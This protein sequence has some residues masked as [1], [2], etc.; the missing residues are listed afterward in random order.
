VARRQAV[1]PTTCEQ[2]KNHHACELKAGSGVWRDGDADPALSDGSAGLRPFEGGAFR[3]APQAPPRRTLQAGAG[4]SI[5]A[6]DLSTGC[7]EAVTASVV[8]GPGVLTGSGDR[9]ATIA[10]RQRTSTL[11][12][13][14]ATH[15]R[16]PTTHSRSRQPATYP[17]DRDPPSTNDHVGKNDVIATDLLLTTHP[18]HSRPRPRLRPPLIGRLGERL[19][20]GLQL[21]ARRPAA[22]LRLPR[23]YG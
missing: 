13:P 1:R 23:D 11:V 19:R 18:L 21:S 5:Q 12:A 3:P 10:A 2:G 4:D 22:A 17:F 9:V 15:R 6:E 20:L 16:E 8:E 14:A 7:P